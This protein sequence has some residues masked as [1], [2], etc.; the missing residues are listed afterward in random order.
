MWL[1]GFFGLPAAALTAKLSL[2]GVPLGFAALLLLAVFRLSSTYLQAE[3]FTNEPMPADQIAR[4]LRHKSLWGWRKKWRGKSRYPFLFG[5]MIALEMT[6]AGK[7][8]KVTYDGYVWTTG[9][10]RA[11][12]RGFWIGHGTFDHGAIFDSGNRPQA[13]S[14]GLQIARITAPKKQVMAYWP[15]ASLLRRIVTV[16]AISIWRLW[17][18]LRGIADVTR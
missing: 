6:D 14:N 4:Y 10:V 5:A 15:R 9:S 8:G 11:I 2:Y 17:A 1:A 13:S 16:A 7:T 12:D 3:V 18:R